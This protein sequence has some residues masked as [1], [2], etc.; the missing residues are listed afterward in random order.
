MGNAEIAAALKAGGL[1]MNSAEPANTVGSILTRRFDQVGD[2]VKV[3]RGVWG[4]QE[5]Y[6]NRS[7]KK[8]PEKGDNGGGGDAVSDATSAPKQPSEPPLSAPQGSAT[9]LAQVHPLPRQ[10]DR[11]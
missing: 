11:A 4:L 10:R 8:K 2:I 9:P 7:F 1:V 3:G 6:P 5:W